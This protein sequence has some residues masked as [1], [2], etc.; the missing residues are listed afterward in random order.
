MMTTYDF[1]DGPGPAHQH[2][3]PDGTIGGWVADRVAVAPTA[4]VYGDA[5]VY[6][7]AQVSGGEF[8]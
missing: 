2:T 7:D 1:G 5:R 3:N 4:W 6:G 8:G